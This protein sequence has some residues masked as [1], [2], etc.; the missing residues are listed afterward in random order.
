VPRLVVFN[1]IDASRRE[2][3]VERDPC[4]SIAAVSVSAKT[5]E[6]LELLRDAILEFA[7][8]SPAVAH[9]D[10]SVAWSSAAI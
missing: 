5:G 2:P 7:H 4:G 1:K 9:P 10:G 3:A 6:G 8:R